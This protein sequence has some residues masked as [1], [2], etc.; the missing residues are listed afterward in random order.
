MS[1]EIDPGLAAVN[2]FGDALDEFNAALKD[3][4]GRG[5]AVDLFGAGG[6]GVWS[7]RVIAPINAEV[8]KPAVTVLRRAGK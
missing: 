4:A 7:L 1:R 6:E 3:V 5:F 8:I 2:R